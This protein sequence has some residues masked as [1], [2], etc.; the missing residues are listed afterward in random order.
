MNDIQRK[1]SADPGATVLGIIALLISITGCCCGILAIPSVI[2]SIIGLVWAVKSGN[3][4][5]RSP[6]SYLAKSY[7]NIKT[8]KILNIIALVLSAIALVVSM[9]WFGSMFNNPENFFEQL[10]NGEFNVEVDDM[11]ED[12]SFDDT[13]TEEEIDTWRYEDAVDSTTAGDKVIEVEEYEQYN[14]SI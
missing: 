5:K 7:N 11:N 13:T 3:A 6:E 12:D 4:Y 2:M 10:E 14:D 8:A 1:L 9:I